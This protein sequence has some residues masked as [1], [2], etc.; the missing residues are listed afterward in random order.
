MASKKK[1]F[2]LDTNVLLHDFKCLHNF[3]NNDIVLPIT[4]LEELDKFKKG[5]DQINFNA[6][7]IARDLSALCGDEVFTKGVPLG[8]G[9][10][11]LFIETNHSASDLVKKNFPEITQDHKILAITEFVSKKRKE[12]VI[13]VS[14]DVNLRIKAKALGI[15]AEDYET[16]KVSDMNIFSGAEEITNIDP[17]FIYLMYQNPKPIEAENIPLKE[18]PD[19]NKHFVFKSADGEQTAPVYFELETKQLHVVQKNR[20][21][22]IEPRNTEQRFALQALLNP[23]IPLVSITGKAGTGKTLLALAAALE[24]AD[25]FDQILLARPIIP[26]SNR[27]IGFLPGDVKEKIGPYMLPLFDNL[28]VIKNQKGKHSRQAEKVDQMLKDEHLVITPLAYIRGRSLSK[29]YFII[30]EAQNLTP[31]EVKTIIT[32]AGE[33][34]K[35]VFTGDIQQIDTPYLDARSNGLSYLTDRMRKEKLFMHIHL[36]KGE[37]SALAEIASNLL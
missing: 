7:Q 29:V 4:V 21:Y 6:R 16:D 18:L 15:P 14:K 32:R 22:G 31:H 37:R 30:D 28:G 1:V 11:N 25:D 13:F 20:A 2:V 8:H 33:G 24:M 10:G 5:F 19:E 23:N 12:P 36:Q 17:N 26:L 27:D 34:T 9:L 35:I 3:Q